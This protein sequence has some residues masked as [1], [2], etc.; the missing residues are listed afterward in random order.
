MRRKKKAQW[1]P[2][3]R[4]S[5][6]YTWEKS[7]MMRGISA[8]LY[9]IGIE[10]MGELRR[11]TDY[12]TRFRITPVWAAPARGGKLIGHRGYCTVIHPAY[13]GR[14][15]CDSETKANTGFFDYPCIRYSSLDE[16]YYGEDYGC[17]PL[18]DIPVTGAPG[19]CV[20]FTEAKK[21]VYRACRLLEWANPSEI[22]DVFSDDFPPD[23]V[24]GWYGGHHGRGWY[25]GHHGH[26]VDADEYYLAWYDGVVGPER[27]VTL[28]Q[29]K[30]E[31]KVA[32][33]I[34][35]AFHDFFRNKGV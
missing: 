24:G 12:R 9:N 28:E 18:I 4:V 33:E 14:I 21:R 29:K 31:F 5:G 1:N 20:T 17:A 8:D 11:H 2:Y 27:E 26:R 23:L 13:R 15:E 35:E 32:N 6:S 7:Q 30:H 10:S 34:E 16:E 3:E 19:E 25:G 22:C